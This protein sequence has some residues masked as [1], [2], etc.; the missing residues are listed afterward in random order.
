[1]NTLVIERQTV[2]QNLR[3]V[4]QLAK[5]AVLIGDLSAD[6]YGLGLLDMARL[7]ADEGVRSFVISS[8][9]E[10]ERLRDG[11]FTEERLMTLRSPAD[12]GEL[13]LLVDLGVTCAVG[14]YEAG[15]VLNAAAQGRRTVCDVQMLLDCGAGPYGFRP[16]EM[17]K[18]TSVYRD[19]Q[20][21]RVTGLCARFS[22]S[23]AKARQLKKEFQRFKAAA[24]AIALAGLQPG[25]LHIA[26]GQ[27]LSRFPDC[28]LDAVRLGRELGGLE[29]GRFEREFPRAAY[30]E[31]SVGAVDWYRKGERVG[32]KKLRRTRRVAVLP[33]GTA[34]GFALKPWQPFMRQKAPQIQIG[35]KALPLLGVPGSQDCFVDVTEIECRV[36][37]VAVAG[38]EPLYAK[39][40]RRVFR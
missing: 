10:A 24:A 37:D 30:L 33:V 16:E 38:M 22:D 11:G 2:L 39:G 31:S 35:G 4:K 34:A 12:R 29:T 32:G 13:E 26:D 21:L 14:S 6:A 3:T 15:V 19:M 23:G 8:A 25:F 40:L 17:D 18:I 20:A 27:A 9:R 7:L 36:G 28:R 5:G 1:M